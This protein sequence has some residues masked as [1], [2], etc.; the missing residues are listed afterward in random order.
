[1]PVVAVDNQQ[2]SIRDAAAID[3]A[4]FSAFNPVRLCDGRVGNRVER[5]TLPGV[6]VDTIAFIPV[7]EANGLLRLRAVDDHVR[8]TVNLCAARRNV[9]AEVG[10]ETTCAADELNEC[11]RARIDRRVRDVEIP[12]VAGWKQRQ[13]TGQR[14]ALCR[15]GEKTDHAGADRNDYADSRNKNAGMHQ[16]GRSC[17]P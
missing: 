3:V 2:M 10:M 7:V 14:T 9:P 1:M 8:E 4:G 11:G 12:P 6:E 17:K 16:E 13:R 5:K 15:R